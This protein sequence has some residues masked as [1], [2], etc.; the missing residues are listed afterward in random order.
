MVT[1]LKRLVRVHT[2]QRPGQ[3]CKSLTKLKHKGL[4]DEELSCPENGRVKTAAP[5]TL[6][7]DSSST[8]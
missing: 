2:S 7:M 1:I 4:S 5:D 8:F 6:S 3:M